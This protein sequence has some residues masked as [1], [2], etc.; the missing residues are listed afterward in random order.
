MNLKERYELAKAE[1]EKWGIN[2]D[3]V[4]RKLNE[5]K[6]SIHCWQ[7]DDVTGFEVNE[8]E[9]SGGIAATGNYPGKANTPQELRADLDKALSLIPGKHKINLHAIYAETNGEVV[10]RDELKP[11]HFENWVNW[12]KERGLG[13]D[14]NPTIFSHPKAS[15]GL[16]L[17]HPDKEIRDFWIRHSIACRKIGEYF[18]R[19][20]GQTCLTNIWIPDG[21]KDIPA[22]RLEP[23]RRL[24]ESLDEILKVEI[25]KNYNLDC[26]ESKVF[27]LGAESYTV[28]SNEFYLNYAAKNDIL[29]LLD[30]GHYHPTEVV[31]DKLSAMYLFSDKVALHVSRPVRWD[32]DHVVILDDE[33]KE[34]AKEIV[35]NDALD[36]T[37]IGLDFFDASINRVAAWVI[38]TRNMI[39]ALLNAMLMPHSKLIE[40]QEEGNFTERLALME[41]FKTYPMGDIWNYYCEL[42]NVPVK[43]DWLKE[44]KEYEQEVLLKRDACKELVNA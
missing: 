20:L 24:K 9:L 23:R 1:Y 25:D 32:S 43:E 19:E 4:L 13:L 14:F 29:S 21:Y 27:G 18:G 11:E 35:R 31:S 38:G 42:N 34:I 22:D 17:S 28:G 6:I 36:R 8:Q 37:I 3:E 41:E 12:A 16:T 5:V 33:L 44:V 26:V 2:V 10:E 15:D 30:T 7:G 39:K 40:L